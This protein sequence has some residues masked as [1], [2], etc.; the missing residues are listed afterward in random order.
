M[1]FDKKKNV[2]FLSEYVIRLTAQ[3]CQSSPNSTVSKLLR[4][5]TLSEILPLFPR[6]LSMPVLRTNLP[7][8]STSLLYGTNRGSSTLGAIPQF[9]LTFT[10]GKLGLIYTTCPPVS[11][12]VTS[13]SFS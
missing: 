4:L 2:Q 13:L 3:I 10:K 8:E 7:T 9:P 5:Y 12:E 11:V 1:P 6:E